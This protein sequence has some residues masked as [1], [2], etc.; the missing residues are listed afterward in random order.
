MGRESFFLFSLFFFL[1]VRSTNSSVDKLNESV[2]SV[3][4]A[5]T[6]TNSTK[7]K[8]KEKEKESFSRSGRETKRNRCVSFRDCAYGNSSKTL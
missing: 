4:V 5:A 7:K 3:D 2:C 8:K 1:P 6:K